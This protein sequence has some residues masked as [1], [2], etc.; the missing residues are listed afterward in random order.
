MC[1]G[2]GA[3]FKFLFLWISKHQDTLEIGSEIAQ[4]IKNWTGLGEQRSRRYVDRSTMPEWIVRAAAKVWRRASPH[5]RTVI[6]T[7]LF[8]CHQF[9]VCSIRQVAW[10]FT[11]SCATANQLVCCFCRAGEPLEPKVWLLLELEQIGIMFCFNLFVCFMRLWLLCQAH[12]DVSIEM[13][14]IISQ[15]LL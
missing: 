3:T 11:C 2:L 10:L 5:V 4:K 1:Q 12:R 6:F 13:W 14:P 8:F 9:L 15:L 7:C